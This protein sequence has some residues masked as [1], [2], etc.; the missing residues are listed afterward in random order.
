ML[1]IK[2]QLEEAKSNKKAVFLK[3]YVDPKIDWNYI[4]EEINIGLSTKNIEDLGD[5]YIWKREQDIMMKDLFY[6]QLMNPFPT[7]NSVINNLADEFS[8]IFWLNRNNYDASSIQ[9]FVN[10]VPKNKNLT[11][12]PN[13]P[14]H[15][16]EWDVLFLQLIGSST[17]NIYENQND[18]TPVQSEII[19]PGDIIL[20]PKGVYHEIYAHEPRAGISIGYTPRV[21]L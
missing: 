12:G 17:W 14:S 3:Q 1:D 7:R 4:V 9:Y 21:D 13:S 15:C 11:K 6:I 10:L 20:V 16:D 5:T 18:A 8:K 2:K 19:I